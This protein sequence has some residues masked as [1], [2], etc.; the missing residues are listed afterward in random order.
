MCG[1]NIPTSCLSKP[2]YLSQE[3]E[4]DPGEDN[5]GEVLYNTKCSIDH[6]VGQPLC[7]IVFLFRVNG[8]AAGE[9]RMG[10]TCVWRLLQREVEALGDGY[11]C[12]ECVQAASRGRWDKEH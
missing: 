2:V 11:G 7:V 9:R 5:V 4:G 1:E 10:I 3:V 12:V 6:P 8:L